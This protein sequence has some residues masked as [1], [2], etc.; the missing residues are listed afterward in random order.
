VGE[1]LP[2]LE[3]SGPTPI[4]GST[5]DRVTGVDIR[6]D[7]AGAG[8]PVVILNGLLGLNEHWFPCLGPVI[9]RAE[10]LLLQPPLLEMRGKGL[11]VEGV[12]N[13]I[14]SVLETLVEEPVIVV[15]NSLGG[16]VAL[17]LAHRRPDLVAGLVLIGSSGL[18]EKSFE[19]GV[20]HDPSHEWLTRKITELFHDPAKMLPGLVDMAYAELSRR[21]AARALV[22][23]GRSA[24]RDHLGDILGEIHQPT[25]LLWGRNDIVTPADVAAEFHAKMPRATLRW[26]ERCGHAPQIECPDEV[27]RGIAWFLEH[28]A[29]IDREGQAGVA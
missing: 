12:V 6:V 19:R 1:N 4:T 11:C 7:R 9:T 2:G 3:V 13:L 26:I 22:R 27:A 10:C 25:L 20:Q 16:H 21:T 17:R 24:K 18:F 29:A 23:L 14:E 8:R 15:G 5:R 28:M